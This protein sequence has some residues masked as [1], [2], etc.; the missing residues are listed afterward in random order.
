MSVLNNYQGVGRLTKDP[1][2]RITESGKSV[3]RFAIAINEKYGDKDNTTF[4]D[5][6]AWGKTA[7]SI[8]K[9][10]VKG[11]PI[12]INGKINS[13]TYKDKETDKTRK[14][15][16]VLVN[17]FAFVPNDYKTEE[18]VRTQRI[19]QDGFVQEVYGEG[20]VATDDSSTAFM[21]VETDIP[22]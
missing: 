15:V 14:S 19:E 17:T 13:E 6:R 11:K 16:Y 10:F 12:I 1:E 5:C 20:Y 4:V 9:Y 8:N 18:P 21:D 7:E 2:L 3:V 22:F